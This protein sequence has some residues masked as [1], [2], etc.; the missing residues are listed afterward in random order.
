MKKTFFL[1]FFFEKTSSL[2]VK[3]I[4]VF[5]GH[6]L[7]STSFLKTPVFLKNLKNCANNLAKLKFVLNFAC[8]DSPW[9]KMFWRKVSL[10]SYLKNILV[11]MGSRIAFFL[12]LFFSF[13]LHLEMYP[14]FYTFFFFKCCPPPVVEVWKFCFCEINVRTSE[15][16]TDTPL[17]DNPLLLS[18]AWSAGKIFYLENP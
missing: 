3:S 16:I 17:K 11:M 12:K 5:L 9:P 14:L 1:D 7:A 15:Y 2:V 8:S 6:P 13:W 4:N 18:P 10:E